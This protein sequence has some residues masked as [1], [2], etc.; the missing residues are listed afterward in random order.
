VKRFK[1]RALVKLDSAGDG[2]GQPSLPTVGGRVVLRAHHHDTQRD[3][4]FGA[5]VEA[6][7]GDPLRPADHSIQLTMTVSG[8]D[9][10]DYLE[11]GDTFVLWR[12]HDIGQGVISRRLFFLTD[13]P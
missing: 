4:M 13:G 2:T 6:T 7:H 1:Y 8:D 9:V 5:L 11:P 3:K 10:G 12:G